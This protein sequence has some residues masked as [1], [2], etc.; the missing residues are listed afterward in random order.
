MKDTVLY[1]Q[2]L[3]L[4]AP[5][6]V[7]SVELS[8]NDR[9]VIIE[10]AL[11]RGQFSPPASGRIHAWREREWRHLDTFQFETVIRVKVPQ[12]RYSDGRLEDI[13]VPW[14]ERYART[15]RLMTGFVISLLQAIPQLQSVSG[16]SGLERSTVQEIMQRAAE[17]GLLC[18]DSG[19][20]EEDCRGGASL[21]G[22]CP[23]PAGA[24]VP[25]SGERSAG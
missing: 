17:R 7:R 24:W 18:Q 10:V 23:L 12:I 22:N 2:L 4:K 6:S 25:P 13:D 15:T 14:A 11:R 9:R 20:L 16:I 21:R 3:G 5:W 1:E 19:M 8:A